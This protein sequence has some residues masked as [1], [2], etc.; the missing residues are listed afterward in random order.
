M[1]AFHDIL[2]TLKTA[3][4]PPDPMRFAG[5]SIPP[6]NWNGELERKA[7][8]TTGAKLVNEKTNTYEFGRIGID[9]P[10]TLTDLDKQGLKNRGLDPN[11]PAY[12]ACKRYFAK[13]PFCTKDDL[14]ANS[15]G[16]DHEGIKPH[17]AKD[18]L[19]AFRA[20]LVDKPS[21]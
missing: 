5:H 19:G 12:A 16:P 18:V 8:R 20:Y 1:G 2:T 6:P 7:D 10:E 13:M 11:N 4:A 9:I 15:S 3:F 14:A 21:F 17:T